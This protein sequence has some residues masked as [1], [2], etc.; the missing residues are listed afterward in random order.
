LSLLTG[1]ERQRFLAAHNAARSDVGVDPVD[2]S[3]ELSNHALAS[4]TQQKDALI[5]AAKEDWKKPAA[6]LPRHQA[7]RAYGENVAGWVGTKPHPADWAVDLWLREKTDFDKL[8]AIA[9]YRVGD[10]KAQSE[11]DPDETKPPIIVGHYTQIVWRATNQIGA[12]KLDFDLTDDH[13]NHRTY[14]AIIC[15]YTPPGN[16][17]GQKPF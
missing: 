10:E 16:R 13:G 5:A 15:N 14:T 8:N 6:V 4:L 2:W 3:N 11:A 9:P 12:A 1:A 7:D 17:R